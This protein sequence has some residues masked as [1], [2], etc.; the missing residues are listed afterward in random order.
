MNGTM[1]YSVFVWWCLCLDI[2]LS[3]LPSA[4]LY[5]ILLTMIM[6]W[7]S[8][9]SIVGGWARRDQGRKGTPQENTPVP[10]G[11][12]IISGAMFLVCLILCQLFYAYHNNSKG[13]ERLMEY[14]AALLTICFGLLLGF[15]DDVLDIPHKYKFFI[16]TIAALPLLV[17]YQ[18][19]TDIVIPKP[20]RFLIV[21]A[22]DDHELTFLGDLLNRFAPI[23]MA[24][25]GAIVKLGL[26]YHFY[27]L[28][29]SVFC[30]NAIN[31]YAGINGLEAGQSVVIGLAIVVM[32]CLELTHENDPVVFTGNDEQHLMSLIIMVPFVATSLGLLCLNWWP[33]RI[34]VGDTFT[35]FAGM[36]FAVA[37]IL[38]H[39]SKTLLLLFVPQI[40]NFLYSLPQL[41]RIIKLPRHRLPTFDPKTGLMRASCLN[42]R[43]KITE[44]GEYN[45]HN[46]T[47][48]N[49]VLQIFGPMREDKLCIYLLILQ[50]FCCGLGLMV[51]YGVAG[52]IY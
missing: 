14:D 40:F 46:L 18:G 27:M 9:N 19:V 32:N 2:P 10:E 47:L 22:A 48:I 26:F 21:S 41:M 34:F 33:A 7:S 8:A 3:L 44:D 11:V 49:L 1:P 16:P 28:L 5:L 30:T 50:I 52:Y 51:R 4:L 20:L 36:T 37:A 25:S 12:G 6:V 42:D 35:H 15:C 43:K 13:T 23:D 38:G 45:Y 29:L 17:S 39:F 31:I 24:S